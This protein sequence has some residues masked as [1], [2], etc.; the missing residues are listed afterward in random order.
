MGLRLL[1][2]PVNFFLLLLLFSSNTAFGN[3]FRNNNIFLMP[4]IFYSSD[5]GTG[6][7]AS[8]IYLYNTESS[9]NTNQIWTTGCYTTKKHILMSTQIEHNFN[10]RLKSSIDLVV[11]KYPGSFYGVGTNS[12]YDNKEDYLNTCFKVEISCIRKV[13]SAIWLGPIYKLVSESISEKKLGGMLDSGI[14]G[15]GSTLSSGLGYTAIYDTRDHEFYPSSGTMIT[16]KQ[17]VYL[18]QLGSDKLHSRHE[19]DFRQFVQLYGEN[20]LA[21][22]SISKLADG[23]TPVLQLPG[24]GNDNIF[25]GYHAGRFRDKILTIAQLEYR[26]P[27]WRRLKGTVFGA[28]ATLAD[29]LALLSTT[30]LKNAGGVGLRFALVP[31]KKIHLRLDFTWNDLSGDENVTGIYLQFKEAF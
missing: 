22:Q 23:D 7:G 16:L 20:I 17:L 30:N 11:R 29:K 5:T 28:T 12:E 13:S 19:L 10:S 26:F 1:I 2:R 8:A 21:F 3:F 9:N 24:I 15:S 31:E 27:I 18:K 4:V 25:R 6:F 14:Y